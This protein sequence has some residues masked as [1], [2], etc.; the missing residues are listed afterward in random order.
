MLAVHK[1][2]FKPG[3]YPTLNGVNQCPD[4]LD[5]N[6][7]RSEYEPPS[8]LINSIHKTLGYDT[9]GDLNNFRPKCLLLC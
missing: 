4:G 3:M 9:N 8:G 5:L 2:F 1:Q 6:K 7:L